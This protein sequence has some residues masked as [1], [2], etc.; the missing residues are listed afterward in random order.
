VIIE[1]IRRVEDEIEVRLV[2][3][4]GLSGK[5]SIQVHLPHTAA[6]RTDVRG[7][8]RVELPG[9]PA[10]ELDLRPQEIVTLRLR[11][12]GR[13]TTP[14]PIRSFERLIPAS[15]RAFMRDARHPNLVG[16]PPAAD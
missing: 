2:E 9:G 10:Y 11:T 14:E 13:V 5:G 3:C 1:S 7:A 4:L 8:N 16:H 12:T 6:A 15:K